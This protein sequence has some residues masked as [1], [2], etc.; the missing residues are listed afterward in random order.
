MPDGR[1]IAVAEIFCDLVH[2]KT[3]LTPCKKNGDAS[4]QCDRLIAGTAA[5]FGQFER[6]MFRRELGQRVDFGADAFGIACQIIFYKRN[7]FH[8][9]FE[10][11]LY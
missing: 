11:T 10:R 9:F 6:K 1:R 2:L 4:G 3:R 7:N 5:K 8:R